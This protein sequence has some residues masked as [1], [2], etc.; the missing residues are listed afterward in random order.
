MLVETDRLI[1]RLYTE[2]DFDDYFSYILEPEL[3]YMLGLNGVCKEASLRRV[4]RE[5][6]AYMTVRNTGVS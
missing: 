4:D 5:A 6:S 1:V 3:Q 2:K